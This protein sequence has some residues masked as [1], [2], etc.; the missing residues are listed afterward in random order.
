M[1]KVDL[2]KLQTLIYLELN[3]S[4]QPM[5]GY[6]LMLKMHYIGLNYSHQHMYASVSKMNLDLAYKQVEGERDKILYSIPDKGNYN[7]DFSLHPIE[8]VIAYPDPHFVRTKKSQVLRDLRAETEVN[9]HPA[10]REY[11][12]KKL[13]LDLETLD[14]IQNS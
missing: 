14:T 4:G 8:S 2:N 12:L 10:V 13:K 5:T 3:E 7:L 1:R 11:R 9:R 6:D